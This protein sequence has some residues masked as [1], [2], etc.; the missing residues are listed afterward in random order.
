[1]NGAGKTRTS[2]KGVAWRWG[3]GFRLC[4][5]PVIRLRVRS[6]CTAP[7]HPTSGVLPQKLCRSRSIATLD[8]EL[9]LL[10]L[11]NAPKPPRHRI[12]TIVFH[13]Q[14][15][16]NRSWAWQEKKGY[17]NSRSRAV[18]ATTE[19]SVRGKS[20]SP[21]AGSALRWGLHTCPPHPKAS[22]K[23]IQPE[24]KQDEHT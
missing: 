21:E 5:L 22:E 9:C 17:L 11:K 23:K 13:K 20:N 6:F 7:P 12:A 1:M 19:K 24:E 18:Q 8:T 3:P 16:C 2:K 4:S 10:R 15:H 14:K